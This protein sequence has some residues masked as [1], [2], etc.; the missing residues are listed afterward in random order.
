MIIHV[1][2]ES[3]TH[4]IDVGDTSSMT[5]DQKTEALHNAMTTAGLDPTAAYLITGSS[6]GD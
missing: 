1:E 5:Q 3:G 6:D 4:N 2:T